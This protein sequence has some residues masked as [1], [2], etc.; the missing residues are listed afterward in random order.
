MYK[1]HDLKSDEMSRE[2]V[3]LLNYESQQNGNIGD[4]KNWLGSLDKDE[5]YNFIKW[6]QAERFLL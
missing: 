1:Q 2:E 3:F 6:L 4:F 5:I